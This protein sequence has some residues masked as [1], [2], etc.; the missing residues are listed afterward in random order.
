MNM[1]R[2]DKQIN[3][4]AHMLDESFG[5]QSNVPQYTGKL[6]GYKW[7][8]FMESNIEESQFLKTFDS[9]A[10][11]I[12]AGVDDIM[13]EVGSWDNSFCEP[14]DGEFFNSV[15]EAAD[16]FKKNKRVECT[17]QNSFRHVINVKRIRASEMP[18]LLEI[19]YAAQDEYDEPIQFDGNNIEAPSMYGFDAWDQIL[20]LVA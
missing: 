18:K 4:W 1:A 16:Y 17:D 7:A 15:E 19:V 12:Q 13:K 20:D 10:A 2:L 14:N 11:A 5:D 3:Y 9:E 8:Y 6:D